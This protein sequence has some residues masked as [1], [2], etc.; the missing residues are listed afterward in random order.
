MTLPPAA[1]RL[2][3]VGAGMA[4]VAVAAGAFGTHTLRDAVTPERLA[5]WQ[6]S[7]QYGLAH[8][9]ATVLAATLVAAGMLRAALAGWLF[10]A[11]GVLF[12]GSLY[13]LVLLDAPWLGAVTPLGGTAFIAG[14][15]VLAA[16]ALTASRRDA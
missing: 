15:V 2:V 10:V 16:S 14:W 4:A 3:A 12:S 6:T 5:T 13:A 7:A 1:A 9:L 11:G 8:A